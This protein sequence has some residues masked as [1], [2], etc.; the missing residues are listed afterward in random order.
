MK[1]IAALTKRIEKI[2]EAAEGL[3]PKM[4][5]QDRWYQIGCLLRTAAIRNAAEKEMSEE[6]ATRRM[7]PPN[8]REYM[9]ARER[10]EML[11]VDVRAISEEMRL[12]GESIRGAQARD[13]KQ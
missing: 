11:T 6:E 12:I 3:R 10:G 4:T 13:G 5:Q 9:A 8:L 7:I 1:A 2:E